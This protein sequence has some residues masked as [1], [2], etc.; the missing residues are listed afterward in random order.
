MNFI[1][2]SSD[3]LDRSGAALTAREIAQQPDVWR[4][5]ERMISGDAG[6]HAFLQPLLAR[7][8]LQ[9]VLTGAG[10]SACI[11]ECLAPIITK[12]YG[13]R[14]HAIATTDLVATPESCIG[15]SPAILLVSFARSG[16]SPESLAALTVA[17]QLTPDCHHLIITCN[18]QGELYRQ[19]CQ[20]PRT[21][22]VALP[23]ETNDRGF[24]MTSSFSSMLLSAALAFD[25]LPAGTPMALARWA[26]HI[27]QDFPAVAPLTYI[28]VR[29]VVYLGHGPFKAL[30]R[31][32]AL[33]ML[34]LTDGQVVGMSDTPLGFRHGPKTVID[35]RTLVLA[36]LSNNTHAR[37]YEIDLLKEL[38]RDNLAA[39][40]VAVTAGNAAVPTTDVIRIPGAELVDELDLCF[41]YVVLA[42]S[43][44][45]QQSLALG[46][47]PDNPNARGVVNRVVQGVTVYPWQ[48][49]Q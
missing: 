19:G 26:S 5:V 31:E 16:N 2:Q 13:M 41:P 9:I 33:K 34:E 23:E 18:R 7:P 32:A 20:R 29:R 27:L 3:E 43:L 46:L 17:E 10:T 8:E 22:V 47:R 30:A 4:A 40:I 12:R 48:P 35:A 45:L 11:G 14:A 49:A 25:L 39:R 28:G 15:A 21:H 36:F 37:R 6:L 24:A 44:A 42:Q 38:C 1:N